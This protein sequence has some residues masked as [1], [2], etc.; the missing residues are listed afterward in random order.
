[1][2]RYYALTA[3]ASAEASSEDYFR[4]KLASFGR[5]LTNLHCCRTSSLLPSTHLSPSESPTRVLKR[6]RAGLV[7]ERRTGSPHTLMVTATWTVTRMAQRH[8]AQRVSPHLPIF[9]RLCYIKKQYEGPMAFITTITRARASSSSAGGG[10]TWRRC[11]PGGN[12]SR[13]N[14]VRGMRTAIWTHERAWEE[15]LENGRRGDT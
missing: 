15:S 6:Q 14:S 11:S 7:P 10:Y 3:E 5:I 2:T 13:G 4:R 1:M 9:E 8:T 12:I